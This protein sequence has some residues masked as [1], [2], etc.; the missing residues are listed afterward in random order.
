LL[1]GYTYNG[2]GYKTRI[3]TNAIAM[4]G[5]NSWLVNYNT[6]EGVNVA[7]KLWWRR[8]IDSSNS[9]SGQ[10]AARYGFS[11]THFNAI[12]R[13]AYQHNNKAWQR[14]NWSVGVEGGKYVYQ[15]N[16]NSTVNNVFNT[17]STLFYGKNYL[18]LYE[19]LG[20]AAFVSRNY[21]NGFSWDARISYQQRIPVENTTNYTLIKNAEE[22]ITP[23][24]PAV[25]G[26]SAWVKNDAAII[27]V[28][29]S[30]QPGY[31]YTQLPDY[32]SPNGSRWPV[33]TASYEKGIPN[34]INSKSDFD[35]WRFG[36]KDQV[37]LKLLGDLKYDVAAGGF[38]NDN[39]V[40]MADMMHL[41]DN[42]MTIAAPYM[43]SF[44]LAPYYRYSNT[45][46]LYG[47]LHLEYYMKGL[48]TN[49]IPL[50]RQARWYFV[51][52]T[53][54]FYASQNNYYTEAFVGIDNLGYKIFRFLRVDV[55]QSWNSLKQPATGLR[56]G[57]NLGGVI[58][59]NTGNKDTWQ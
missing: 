58:R 18:K 36:I 5:L 50:L 11:N 51:L 29:A 59:V 10:L 48:L 55:V 25:A 34:I 53:N 19:G 23:N 16:I 39:Y 31:T 21:G 41:A 47:E 33:F 37:D 3:A 28:S 56:I 15:F 32:K 57:I 14:K 46:S 1:G 2:K 45:A 26:A 9:L 24:T 27:R 42:Q 30:Y 8:D 35:K 13:L 49:K 4:P 17:I 6:V 54:T 20:G 44:Q 38:L 12:A 7:P 43:R 52:G 40:S 22:K